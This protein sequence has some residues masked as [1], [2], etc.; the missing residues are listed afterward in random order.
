MHPLPHR[1]RAYARGA[2]TGR[3]AVGAD[4]AA[5]I[6]TDAPP[7]FGGPPNQWSPETLL[8]AAIADCYILSFR[9]CARAAKLPW[10][11]IAVDVEGI[12]DRDQGGMRFTHFR[13]SPRLTVAPGADQAHAHAALEHAKRACLVTNSLSASCELAASVQSVANDEA[14]VT[15]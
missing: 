10:L 1:Y 2:A 6:P 13:V 14:Q 4:G 5:E 8:V 7:E 12:L 9:A 3:V 15:G 11:S